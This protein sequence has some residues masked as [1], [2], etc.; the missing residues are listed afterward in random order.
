MLVT[1]TQETVTGSV[2]TQDTCR[3]TCIEHTASSYVK[4]KRVLSAN[5]EVSCF[6]SIIISCLL[7]RPLQSQLPVK[8][9]VLFN[10]WMELL[11]WMLTSKK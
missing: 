6:L 11:V 5:L 10:L 7:A 9:K 8:I 4:Y 1:Y 2:V 3:Y